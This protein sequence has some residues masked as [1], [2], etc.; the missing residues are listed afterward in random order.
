MLLKWRKLFQTSS[1]GVICRDARGYHCCNAR[2]RW[3]DLVFG[4][5]WKEGGILELLHSDSLQLLWQRS[6][7]VTD[8]KAK[9]IG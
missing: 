8:T 9:P 4:R 6:F 1:R 7:S 2:S 5:L 3:S